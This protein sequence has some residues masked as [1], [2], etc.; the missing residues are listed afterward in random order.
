M[1]ARRSVT[2]CDFDILFKNYVPHILEKIFLSLDYE[3][4]KNC[5]G[6]NYTWKNLLTSES[7]QRKG[8][9]VFHEEL[10]DDEGELWKAAREGN[11]ERIRRLLSSGLLNVNCDVGS[12]PRTTPLLE[13]LTGRKSF[14]A[15]N[16]T[17]PLLEAVRIYRPV[18]FH[19]VKLLL[20]SGADPNKAGAGADI[21]PLCMAAFHG[22]T[23]V[24]KLLLDRGADQ[25][26]RRE[27]PLHYAAI[28]GH[29]DV[30]T[31]LLNAELRDMVLYFMGT[32][33][34]VVQG[35]DGGSK[36]SFIPFFWKE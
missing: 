17:T 23:N 29:K 9:S 36:R 5:I 21:T 10:L 33:I 18:S 24:V 11:A 14:T 4:Y 7:Y 12:N 20:E 27:T 30:V 1:D 26:K 16:R 6:V 19:I 15:S 22:M 25:N 35:L 32:K 2:P 13:P 28:G 8:K 31:M 3:S 34:K